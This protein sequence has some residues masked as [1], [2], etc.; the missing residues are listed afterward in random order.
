MPWRVDWVN[1]GP[2]TVAT[3]VFSH[4][5]ETIDMTVTCDGTDPSVATSTHTK[6]P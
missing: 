5:A 2:A 4:G 6:Q 1:P 3:A